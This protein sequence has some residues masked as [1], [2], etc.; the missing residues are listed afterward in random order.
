MTSMDAKIIFVIGNSRSG[1]TMLSRILGRSTDAFTFN[2]LHFFEEIWQTV[3]PPPVISRGSAENYVAKLMAVQRE[4]YFANADFQKYKPEAVQVVATHLGEWS[5]PL[6]YAAFVLYES[7]LHSKSIPVE[8]TPFN[9]YYLNAILELFPQAHMVN[10]IRD[11]RAVLLSQKYRWRR[12]NLGG[13]G[14]PFFEF[15]RTWLNYHPITISLLW[16]SG[17]K[18]W[19]SASHDPRVISLRFEDLVSDPEVQVRR[20][21]D[22]A[23]LDYSTDMLNIPQIG[24]SLRQDTL[25]VTGVDKRAAD[26][27][28]TGALDS[29]ELWLCQK[30]ASQSL[31]MTGYSI[32]NVKPN[33]IRL[34]FCFITFVFKSILVF[35]INLHRARNPIQ[36]VKRRLGLTNKL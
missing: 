18:A 12:R 9:L 16:R 34:F 15:V 36:A 14:I 32:V 22:F 25:G 26:C 4:G 3:S 23:G 10:I 2:E 27:W 6:A 19:R 24:S 7:G 8:Q 5:A 31:E 29:A 30:I 21:C 1:T 28:R 35:L 33:I 13:K 20:L 17:V 11:P